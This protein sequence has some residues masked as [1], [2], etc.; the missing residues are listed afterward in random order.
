M[1]ALILATI[2]LG[3]ESRSPE[4]VYSQQAAPVNSEPSLSQSLVS[5][6][7]A[8]AMTASTIAARSAS[9]W[10]IEPPSN[11]AHDLIRS[12]S[13]VTA[14]PGGRRHFHVPQSHRCLG[15]GQR[16]V[17]GLG[18]PRSRLRE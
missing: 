8:Y 17:P 7:V 11:M 12:T 3:P 2:A 18:G 1:L 14:E 6:A 10:S 5:T 4:P 9:S 13:L 15:P 16:G